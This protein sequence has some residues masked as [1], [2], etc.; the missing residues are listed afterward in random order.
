MPAGSRAIEQLKQDWI[1]GRDRALDRRDRSSASVA[2]TFV[3]GVPGMAPDEENH[4]CWD[5]DLH[6]SADDQHATFRLD[7]ADLEEL[8]PASS[9]PI[10]GFVSWLASSDVIIAYH[11]A[12]LERHG[13][14]HFVE[15]MVPDAD[16]E[17]PIDAWL[18][19]ARAIVDATMETGQPAEHADYSN[20]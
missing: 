2:L 5:L 15:I 16:D 8:S 17:P 10:I 20:E 6:W 13:W 12:E 11:D 3:H 4:Q 18:P 1:S 9:S 14:A 7:I 19:L